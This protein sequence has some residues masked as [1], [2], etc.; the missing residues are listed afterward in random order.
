MNFSEAAQRYLQLRIL[1][2]NHQI[3]QPEFDRQAG[4]LRLLGPDNAWWQIRATDGVWFRWDGQAWNQATPPESSFDRPTD[5]AIPISVLVSLVENKPEVPSADDSSQK[6]STPPDQPAQPIERQEPATSI[7]R[8]RP[9]LDILL[10]EAMIREIITG[11]GK[12]YQVLNPRPVGTVKGIAYR[13]ATD[14]YLDPDVAIEA[15]GPDPQGKDIGDHTPSQGSVPISVSAGEIQ[16]SPESVSSQ[17]NLVSSEQNPKIQEVGPQ[18]SAFVQPV[19][20]PRFQIAIN[21]FMDNARGWQLNDLEVQS[22]QQVAGN[23]GGIFERDLHQLEIPALGPL[24]GEALAW[25]HTLLLSHLDFS[26]TLRTET[27][28]GIAKRFII[29]SDQ[30]PLYLATSRLA[31]EDSQVLS[32]PSRE[33]GPPLSAVHPL[34]LS[35]PVGLEKLVVETF[36]SNWVRSNPVPEP[37][38]NKDGHAYQEL[39]GVLRSAAYNRTGVS[40]DLARGL[41]STA[42]DKISLLSENRRTM[43]IQEIHD[44]AQ[45]TID[46]L[47]YSADP[48]LL[49][50]SFLQLAAT[51]F[52]SAANPVDGI[53]SLRQNTTSA[54]NLCEEYASVAEKPV[55]WLNT[56]FAPWALV[57]LTHSALSATNEVLADLEMEI[58]NT[59]SLLGYTYDRQREM[60]ESAVNKLFVG[61]AAHALIPQLINS[62]T[63]QTVKTRST[64]ILEDAS[65]EFTLAGDL[66]LSNE[67]RQVISSLG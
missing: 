3:S 51:D 59:A 35:N 42:D 16:S 55:L 22:A 53:Q 41:V 50:V 27:L 29:L 19:P 12:R 14:G 58:Q 49:V 5:L 61:R 24:A 25:W 38:I 28:E 26:P 1:L 8:G 56:Q 18:L 32:A 34:I 60:R 63:S 64:K 36:P 47:F 44:N 62:P 37:S 2:E 57:L 65:E 15:L 33:G 52:D 45:K 48:Y 54:L 30:P 40:L 66:H 43:L 6:E 13:I 9:A 20:S 23:L 11:S 21:F 10:K 67:C 17:S 7:F 31:K 4:E 39:F 46:Q